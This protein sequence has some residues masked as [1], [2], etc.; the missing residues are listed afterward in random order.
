MKLSEISQILGGRLIGDDAE[1]SFFCSDSRKSQ[2]NALFFA[3]KGEKTDGHNFVCEVYKAG[4]F[5]VVKKEIKGSSH[6]MVKDVRAS[7]MSL[8][9]WKVK[10]SSFK[11]AVT[12]SNGK[13]TTKNAIASLL[14]NHGR[15]CK[16]IENLNTD[17]GISLSI[18]NNPE[19]PKYCVMEIGARFS[20][21]VE[22]V[23]KIFEPD[24]SVITSIGS[25]HSALMDV[26]REKSSISKYTKGIVIYDGDDRVKKRVENKG[27]ILK[28]H[29]CDVKYEDLYTLVKIGKSEVKLNGIWG[30]GQ[31]KDLEL[32]LNV[33]D[34]LKLKWTPKELENLFLS[35]GRMCFKR[36]KD[37]IVVD[38]TYNA[39][40]ESLENVAKTAFDLRGR[41]VMW[42]LAPMKEIEIEDLDEKLMNIFKRFHPKDVFTVGEKFYPFGRPYSVEK[43]T[44][45]VKPNDIVI[46]KGSRAYKMERIAKEIRE[47]LNG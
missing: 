26:V 13:T 10:R 37:F 30:K 3:L 40:L 34:E 21:D 23:A 39:N 32:A 44:K 27:K 18:L 12:G 41:N 9:A 47:A 25:S 6:I 28:S 46:V 7:L 5:A 35:E 38:D 43:I 2:K 45:K 14:K 31:I 42:V 29:I 36:I 24:L 11:I 19:N 20:G 8:A 17:V 1:I 16:T 22:R 15:V 4:G 33:M